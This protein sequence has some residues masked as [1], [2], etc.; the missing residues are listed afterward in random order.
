MGRAKETGNAEAFGA[1]L[2]VD[3]IMSP[4]DNS[5]LRD[6]DAIVAAFRSRPPLPLG[7]TMTI[8]PIEICVLSDWAYAFG[9]DTPTYTPVGASA[10]IR[11]RAFH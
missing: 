10:P 2:A 3:G 4:P 8:T 7:G 6:R 11:R 5:L 9:V 1:T